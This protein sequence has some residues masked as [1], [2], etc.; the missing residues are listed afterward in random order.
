MLIKKQFYKNHRTGQI[1]KL[2]NPKFEILQDFW[3]TNRF[4]S[5]TLFTH[6]ASVEHHDS[7]IV[8]ETIVG[9][10]RSKPR[11]KN[12][13]IIPTHTICQWYLLKSK[14][15]RERTPVDT[16]TA[17]NTTAAAAPTS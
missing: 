4:L 3:F 11:P 12:Y 16:E 13:R 5:W 17:H 7:A 15:L 2:S 10:F 8:I 14:L 9:D 6:I 1:K